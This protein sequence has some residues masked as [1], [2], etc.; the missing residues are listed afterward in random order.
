MYSGIQNGY[1]AY[2]KNDI[3]NLSPLNI[4][5]RLYQ[6]LERHLEEARMA[7]RR[8]DR[9]SKGESLSK[10]LSIVG[11]LQA[12]LNMEQGGEIADNL[13]ALYDY[14]IRELS[15]ANILNDEGKIDALLGIVRTIAEAWLEL[16][17]KDNKG[18][19]VQ[20][21]NEANQSASRQIQAAV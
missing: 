13:F 9:A 17:Q 21:S 18:F 5:S 8:G 15:Y 1:F 10:A 19:I 7:I 16:A 6:A 20:H 12:A 14:M 3:L 2:Q 11:E 4:V